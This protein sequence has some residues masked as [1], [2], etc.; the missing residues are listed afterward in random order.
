MKKIKPHIVQKFDVPED[1]EDYD[2]DVVVKV[3]WKTE[4]AKVKIVEI[5]KQKFRRDASTRLF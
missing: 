4:K 5:K 1:M 3:P 2:F